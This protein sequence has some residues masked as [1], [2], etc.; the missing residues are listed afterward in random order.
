M[1]FNQC[2]VLVEA[3]RKEELV[4][5]DCFE[6]LWDGKIGILVSYIIPDGDEKRLSVDS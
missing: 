1:C 3:E 6:A 5:E 4:S 2:I